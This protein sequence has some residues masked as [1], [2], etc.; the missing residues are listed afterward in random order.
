M[1][2]DGRG[3]LSSI[4]PVASASASVMVVGVGLDSVRVKVWF[5]SYTPSGVVG[6]LTVCTVPPAV[7]VSVPVVSVKSALVPSAELVAVLSLSTSEASEV[8]YCTVTS[9]PLAGDSLTLKST[10]LPSVPL[11]SSTLS[12]STSSSRIVPV[13]SS[14][15]SPMVAGFG[16]DSVSVKSWSAS[17]SSSWVVCTITCF[18]LSPGLKV[19]VPLAAVKS[20]PTPLTEAV[21]VPPVAAPVP[22]S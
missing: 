17:C 6:T 4:V 10:E 13:A 22:V 14:L 12:D 21:A 18:D 5:P 19:S 16:F 3:S 20:A 7:I 11:A 9:S 1:L 2:S 8:A 15:V